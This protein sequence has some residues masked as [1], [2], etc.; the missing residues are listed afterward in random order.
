MKIMNNF[1]AIIQEPKNVQSKSE[2]KETNFKINKKKN[3]FK[4][5]MTF[6]VEAG[7]ELV[8]TGE[9]KCVQ[10]TKGRRLRHASC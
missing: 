7:G 6:S 2:R 4:T 5:R 8:L 10:L 3:S 9:A 1:P